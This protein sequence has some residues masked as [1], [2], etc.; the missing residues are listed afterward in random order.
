MKGLKLENLEIELR[1][2][3]LGVSF[4]RYIDLKWILGFFKNF[5]SLDYMILW[6]VILAER[7]HF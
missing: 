3:F 6:L 2:L 4:K 7:T 1:E 5:A